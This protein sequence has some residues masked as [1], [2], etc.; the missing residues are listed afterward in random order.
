MLKAQRDLQVESFGLDPVELQDEERIEFIRWNTLALINEL[1]EMLS[2]TGW[3]PWATSKH[4][5]GA[6]A[7]GE[8]VDAWHFFMNLMWAV[9]GQGA[10]GDADVLADE[11]IERY[12]AKRT[13]NAERQAEGYDGVTGKCPSCKRDMAESLC[14]ESQCQEER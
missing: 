12:F 9:S 4:V 5:N 11:F 13:R 2:E 14:T 1:Q 7:F 6:A 3:K 8:L 10:L